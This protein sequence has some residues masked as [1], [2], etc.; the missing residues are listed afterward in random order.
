MIKTYKA[1]STRETYSDGN[2]I[3]HCVLSALNS[4]SSQRKDNLLSF[5]KPFIDALSLEY[6]NEGVKIGSW[7]IKITDDAG[8]KTYD[9][10]NVHTL[11]AIATNLYLYEVAHGL[12]K[13]FNKGETLT[14]PDVKMLLNLE[15]TYM[16]NYN[17]AIHFKKAYNKNMRNND[18]ITAEI[19][20]SRY[21]KSLHYAD[22]A[23]EQIQSL[24][25]TM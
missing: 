24:Y 16:R 19:M 9:V 4:S 6:T 10:V 14:S 15:E 18:C 1:Y 13:L 17:D 2:E 23:R 22:H 25:K 21:Q 11:E 8:F 5:D 3:I 20:Q 7:E 12:V